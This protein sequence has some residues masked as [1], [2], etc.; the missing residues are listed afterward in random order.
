M[1]FIIILMTINIPSFANSTITWT[2]REPLKTQY[3][4]NIPAMKKTAVKGSRTIFAECTGITLE[5]LDIRTYD[6]DDT[7]WQIKY[8]AKGELRAYSYDDYSCS[9]DTYFRINGTNIYH[10]RFSGTSRG[11]GHTKYYDGVEKTTI[12]RKHDYT[13]QNNPMK[14]NVYVKCYVYT[15]GYYSHGDPKSAHVEHS[16]YIYLNNSPNLTAELDRNYI[17]G[18]DS[19]SITV[20]GK[21]WDIEQDDITIEAELLDRYYQSIA[22]KSKFIA[23]PNATSG[24]S[25]D[26]TLTFNANELP[27]DTSGYMD[28]KI[29]DHYRGGTY[30]RFPIYIDRI[31]PTIST[32][33]TFVQKGGNNLAVTTNEQSEVYLLKNDTPYNVYSDVLNAVSNDK[34]VKIGDGINKSTFTVPDVNGSYRLFAVDNGKNVSKP[35]SSIVQIDSSKPEIIDIVVDG[36]QLIFI[37][38]DA[39]HSKAPTSTDYLLPLENVVSSSVCI[40]ADEDN[41]DYE[42]IFDDYEGDEKYTDRFVF[43]AFDNSMFTNPNGIP[44]IIGQTASTKNGFHEVGQYTLEYQ[45]QDTPVDASETRFNNY[46]KWGNK[47]LIQLLVH[48]RPIANLT[49]N[50]SLSNNQWVISGVNGTGYDLD[51]VDMANKG[52]QDDMYEWKKITDSQYTPGMIPSV[53]TAVEG[54]KDVE[55]IVKYKVQDIEGAWSEPVTF[56]ISAD[57]P[58]ELDASLKTEDSQFSISSIPA[59]ENL[60]AYDVKTI[61]NKL[62]YV[63]MALYNSS[64]SN[65][66]GLIRRYSNNTSYVSQNG[67]KFYW[68]DTAINIPE[69]LADGTYKVIIKATDASNSLKTDQEAFT[70]VVSTPVNLVGSMESKVTYDRTT[71]LTATTSIYVNDVKVT[72]YKGTSRERTRNLVY[73]KTVG[74]TKHWTLNYKE[75]RSYISEGDYMAEFRATTPNDNWEVDAHSFYYTRNTPPTVN[76]LGTDPS[77]IYEGDKVYAN[78]QVNDVDLD[79]LTV[80]VNLSKDGQPLT[81]DGYPKTYTQSPNITN[82]YELLKVP[83]M[84]HMTPGNYDLHV[85]VDDQNGG[86]ATD[87]TIIAPS[88]LSIT[89]QVDHHPQWNDNRIKYNR[90]MTGKDDAPRTYHTYWAGERF[91]LSAQTT[92]IH[93]ASRLTVSKVSVHIIEPARISPQPYQMNLSPLSSTTNRWSG[94]LWDNTMLYRWG[95]SSPEDLTFQF[96]VHYSNGTVKQHNVTITIDDRDTYFKYHRKW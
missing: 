90:A 41:V 1:L 77:F 54:E 62:H 58:I 26:Y 25:D 88:P 4:Y 43:S 15:R 13:S 73:S 11:D 24:Q 10:D 44:D 37:Y 68:V 22:K 93:A 66:T 55:Y 2:G 95:R 3:T 33:D 5:I 34:G 94:E 92:V 87:T 72:L 79:T 47:N 30:K 57:P 81:G 83:L 21:V 86:T 12:V 28:V 91:M 16:N 49:I 32:E 40:L 70:V 71:T 59:S 20:K 42:F 9:D 39:I 14:L 89:G 45:A 52:I 56:I 67:N 85:L 53:V 6:G 18:N 61:F 65:V 46:R 31:K 84:E 35:S 48:R 69:T 60:L 27:T 96:T 23:I 78:I 64:N 36:N 8:K 82:N 51:H 7:Y 38:D 17:N 76:I 80:I 63:D 29:Y 74:D 50:A 19:H 75:D